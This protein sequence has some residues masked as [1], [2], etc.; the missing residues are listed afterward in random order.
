MSAAI[1]AAVIAAGGAAYAANK[2]SKTA[3]RAQN[4]PWEETT[5][6]SPWD[7]ALPYLEGA[8]GL[9]QDIFNQVLGNYTA[10]SGGGGGKTQ[11]VVVDTTG[12]LGGSA[13]GTSSPSSPGSSFGQL[14]YGSSAA[15]IPNEAKVQISQLADSLRG[16]TGAAYNEGVKALHQ[17]IY[18][19][20]LD[21]GV[22]DQ[23]AGMYQYQS[24]G[25]APRA[26]PSGGGGSR[27]SGGSGGGGGG[28]LTPKGPI[29]NAAAYLP[30]TMAEDTF[31]SEHAAPFFDPS[32]LDPANDPTLQPYIDALK[33]EFQQDLDRQL[34]DIGDRSNSI[35]MY[36]GTGQAVESALTR[37]QGSE[38][39]ANQLAAVYLGQRQAAL[40]RQLGLLGE[41]SDRDA[42]A[43]GLA[44]Q[45]RS[46]SQADAASRRSASVAR[47]GQNMAQAQFNAEL[48]RKDAL[49]PLNIFGDYL[50]G[51]GTLT[52]LGPST[53]T[54][55]GVGPRGGG[56][57]NPGPGGTAAGLTS[58]GGS[59]LSLYGMGAFNKNQP[60]ASA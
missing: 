37:E 53:T 34:L 41:I 30:D 27:G 60:A 47:R 54:T 38:A 24:A 12:P 8:L 31:F 50:S 59:L 10:L 48:A 58:L 39:L 2:N 51:L 29:D 5:T 42:T 6:R 1:T 22:K 7:A 57:I 46:I 55:S 49:M 3:S 23:L 28:G 32:V 16:K 36:A 45:D 11:Q 26:A 9:N 17:A 18:G 33:R 20:G 44:I 15:T 4:A 56:Y 13:T 52:Q 43:G 21:Q 40:D 25:A 35:G 14:L 19:S